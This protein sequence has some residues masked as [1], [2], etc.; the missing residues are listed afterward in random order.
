MN[1]TKPTPWTCFACRVEQPAEAKRY[2]YVYCRKCTDGFI[3]ESFVRSV[4]MLPLLLNEG[5]SHAQITQG[6]AEIS[7]K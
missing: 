6:T 4:A 2:G 3:S 1:A 5:F 7:L